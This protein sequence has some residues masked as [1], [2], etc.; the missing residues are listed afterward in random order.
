MGEKGKSFATTLLL[1][2]T[3]QAP[4]SP[5]RARPSVHRSE[6]FV[7][8]RV[9][10]KQLETRTYTNLHDEVI[11]IVT[12][13]VRAFCRYRNHAGHLKLPTPTW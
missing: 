5:A 6:R 3:A 9:S 12:L 11:A 8:H 1:V 13:L 10:F 4:P 2:H 7:E